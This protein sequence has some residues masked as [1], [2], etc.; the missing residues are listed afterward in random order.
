MHEDF[1]IDFEVEKE[2]RLLREVPD[3]EQEEQELTM[4]LVK[5]KQVADGG[6]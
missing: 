4:M 6:R 1:D 2:M 5:F 3:V